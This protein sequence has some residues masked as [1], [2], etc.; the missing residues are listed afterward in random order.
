MS[1]EQ[2]SNATEKKLPLK[3]RV[4]GDE[5]LSWDGDISATD[6]KIIVNKI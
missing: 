4:L 2:K 6:K 3:D 1:E 5:W